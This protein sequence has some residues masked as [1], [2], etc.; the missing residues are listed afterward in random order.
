MIRMSMRGLGSL[1]AAL[2]LL[3]GEAVHA[4]AFRPID[5]EA[6]ARAMGRG[7]NALGFDPM[8]QDPAKRRFQA[9]HF[10]AIRG[11]GFKTVRVILFGFKHMDARGR[12]DERWL[13]SLDWVVAEGTARGLTLILE[14]QDMA[15][16]GREPEACKPKLTAFW[17]QLA[18]RYKDA[19]NTVVFELLNEPNGKLDPV[20]NAW[21]PDLLGAI[22]PTNPT[23][24]VVIDATG[25]ASL[26]RLS[27]L[28]L[29]EADRHLIVSIHY[30][31]P[32]PFTHQGAPWADDTRHLK[33]I[34]WGSDADRRRVKDDFAR[35][36]AWSVKEGRPI[37][38]GEFGAYEKADMASRARYLD[39][40]A[41]EAESHGW[42][43]QVWQFDHDF[44]VYDMGKD[45]WVQPLLEA[46]VPERRTR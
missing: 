25:W 19:P 22:R 1:A 35:A 32:R 18:E 9:R 29:P 34:A 38:L 2:F 45:A 37:V 7:V 6:Q 27:E 21:I 44:T 4:E 31:E 23:R 13:K 10:D 8:W 33:D 28:R 39:A 5:A 40:V 36:Q 43:W 26:G 14:N 11:A 3:A 30:Y 24:N 41:R 20:W 15:W 17:R 16:C 46:L 42:P 12:I